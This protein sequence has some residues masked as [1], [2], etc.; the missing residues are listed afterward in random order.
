MKKGR[1]K[2]IKKY[3]TIIIAILFLLSSS[4]STIQNAFDKTIKTSIDNISLQNSFTGAHINIY[5]TVTT[6]K[7]DN[8]TIIVNIDG[9]KIN[10]SPDICAMLGIYDT[11]KPLLSNNTTLNLESRIPISWTPNINKWYTNWYDN[12]IDSTQ[13]KIDKIVYDKNELEYKMITDRKAWLNAN[14]AKDYDNRLNTYINQIS[15][16][17]GYINALQDGEVDV[18]SE[19][20]KFISFEINKETKTVKQEKPVYGK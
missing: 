5:Y 19:L 11:N 16:L 1:I 6:Y 13:E 18:T 9:N 15:E 12:E 20:S 3:L 2:M 8:Y 7:T 4:C 14:T 10:P 17:K